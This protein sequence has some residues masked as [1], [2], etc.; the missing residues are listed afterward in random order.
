[1]AAQVKRKEVPPIL[2]N[3]SVTPV[4]G[5]RLTFTAMFAMACITKVKL[6]ANAKNAPK[7]YGHLL[8][9]LMHRNKNSR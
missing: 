3:G 8:K 4:T 7:A 1:M 2:I 9:M 5:V 6:N